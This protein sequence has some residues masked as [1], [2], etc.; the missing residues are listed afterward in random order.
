[1]QDQINE[2]TAAISIKTSKV[3]GRI[4][5]KAMQALLR[6]MQ[7]PHLK[8]GKQS[9]KSLTKHGACLTNVDVSGDNIGSF[10]KIARKYNIDF[11]LKR[12]DSETNTDKKAK[13]KY[14]VFFKA[15]DADALTAAFKEYG[16]IELKKNRK[17]SLL[18]RLAKAK[19][20][21]AET[22]AAPVKNRAK[23]GLEH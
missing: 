1:M 19:E 9:V 7:E 2:K 8:H 14:I 5:A 23:G 13:P 6:K 10:N 12:D 21:V 16:K 11:A 4:L 15:K 18:G 17:P 22:P 3:T 20:L